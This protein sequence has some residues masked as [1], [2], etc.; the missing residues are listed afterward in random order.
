MRRLPVFGCGVALLLVVEAVHAGVFP[1]NHKKEPTGWTGEGGRI[2]KLSQDYPSTKPTETYPWKMIDFKT[3]TE[4]YA[5]AVL[6][7]CLE[8]NAD[9]AVDWLV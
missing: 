4:A 9:P 8:G 7:Y 1:D 6:A 3:Q 5:K 2:F